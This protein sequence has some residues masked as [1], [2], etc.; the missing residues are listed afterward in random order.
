MKKKISPVKTHFFAMLLC[1]FFALSVQMAWGQT[2]VS[3][4]EYN[5]STNS[6]DSKVA[7]SCTAVT[8]STTSMSN[9]WYVVNSIVTNSNRIS[10]QG[11]VH[12]ILVDGD[13]LDLS[14]GIY[15]PSGA[16]LIIYGQT[17]GTGELVAIGSTGGHAGI[18][19]NEHEASGASGNIT[20][21]GGK[22]TAQGCN[23]GA[24][25]GSG[26]RGTA[27][28]IKIHGGT[29]N[30]T[31]GA[32]SGSGAGAGIGA[33]YSRDNGTIIITGGEITAYGAIQ[34]GK[35]SAGIGAGSRNGSEGGGGGTIT[36]TGGQIYAIGGNNNSGIGCGYDGSGGTI[37]LSCAHVDDY[38]TSSGYGASTVQVASNKYLNN[39][40]EALS[41]TISDYSKINGKTLRGASKITLGTNALVSGTNVYT[42]SN[43]TYAGPGATVTLGHSEIPAGYSGSFSGY[44]VKDAGNN[45]ITVSQSGGTYTFVMPDKEVTVTAALSLNRIEYN[46]TY[47]GIDGATFT[48]ANP[49]S[50]N[51]ES[52]DIT[53]VN[54][55][56]EGFF[57]VGWT[58]TG[59]SGSS[60]NVTIP[61]GSTDDR[62]YTA[63]WMKLLTLAN[64]EDN[65]ANIATESATAESYRVTLANRTLYCDGTWNT[66]CLPFDLNDFTGTP[67]EGATVKTLASSAFNEGTL[68]MTFAAASA[69]EAGKPYI[70]KF[71]GGSNIE[72]PVFMGVT[73]ENATNA[74]TTTY[75]DFVGSYAP[76][77]D[78]S[79]ILDAHNPEGDAIH[80]AI[81][82][83]VP[84]PTGYLLE[85][86][87]TDAA[88]TTPVTSIPFTTDGNVTMYAKWDPITYTVHFNKNA[89]DAINT[90][91]DQTFTYDEAQNL[92]ANGFSLPCYRFL[93]WSTTENGA[94]EYT[95]ETSVNNLTAV[96]GDEVTLYAQWEYLTVTVNAAG[97]DANY[98][99]DETTVTGLS[100]SITGGE[101]TPTYQWYKNGAAISGATETNCSPLTDV[102][103]DFDYSVKVFNNCGGDSIHIANIH[104][105]DTVIVSTTSGDATYCL[106][107]TPVTTLS[108]SITGGNGTAT[109]QWYVNGTAISSAT[110]DT[111]TLSTGTS[112]DFDYSV[113]VFNDCPGDSIHIANIKV[114]PS[115]LT[116]GNITFTCPDT[117]VTLRYGVCDTLIDLYR[118]L[119]NNMIDMD[120][121][122]DST[123]IPTNHRYSADNSPYTIKWRI[124]DECNDYVEYTQKVT[125]NFPPCGGSETATDGDGIVYRTVRVGCSCWMSENARSTVYA[126]DDHTPI[127]PAPMLYPGA[128]LNTYGYLYTY[129]AATR[130][131]VTRSIP[132]KVQGICPKGWHIP[133]EAELIEMMSM[134]EAEDLM[135]TEHW[136]EPGTDLSGFAMEPSGLYNSELN[137]FEYLYAKGYIWYYTPGTTIYHACAFGAACSTVEIL[138]ASLQSG[139]SVRCVHD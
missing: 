47:S 70:V 51:V 138:P 11:T 36:I 32:C 49:T 117:T 69:I 71:V 53:L 72:N 123:G 77:T 75:A 90:M 127:T 25:I 95:D 2:N 103:G 133:N 16:S 108:V 124:T 20:I 34:G 7:S 60:T 48:T 116:P 94:V 131:P 115:V 76:F 126:D 136:L 84:V 112:G 29:V 59:I 119:V 14:D 19:G 78:V 111:Y 9:G 101:G 65:S 37:T 13:K 107:E 24:G 121:V 85:K 31:G 58:G 139:F 17:N 22:V 43:G 114:R 86:W 110:N 100:V 74:V 52:D 64:D 18:G 118:V 81:S 4:L 55:S 61:T 98:C 125:V 30:A 129:S 80:A 66:L 41:G 134:Y 6:F 35:W 3:Y 122:L 26:H 79:Y 42:L 56:R 21:H 45:D 28:T 62:S 67:L 120:V 132:S 97:S 83:H 87:C 128:D 93:G 91:D 135:S 73:I 40:T 50:Y 104:I 1:C 96:Q 46:I 113:K 82:T 57:F 106:N 23:G 102:S 130:I 12:L 27:S 88:L 109:Y 92:T 8:S 68:T 89:A 44:S 63:T 99:K 15:V 54:P 105:Y 33:G 39:G 5:T 137:R 10:V 38:I